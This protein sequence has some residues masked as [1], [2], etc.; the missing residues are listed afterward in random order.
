MGSGKL[1]QGRTRQVVY[2]AIGAAVF[3]VLMAVRTA[4]DAPW[5]RASIAGLAFVALACSIAAAL[6]K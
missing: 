5:L 3:G 4:A 2:I 6:R 1:L